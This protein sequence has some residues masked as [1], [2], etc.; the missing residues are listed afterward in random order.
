MPNSPTF[1]PHNSD[2]IGISHP[3]TGRRILTDEEVSSALATADAI[4]PP[5][6]ILSG[7]RLPTGYVRIE[8]HFEWNADQRALVSAHAAEALALHAEQIKEQN[9]VKKAPETS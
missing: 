6:V 4:N 3:Y 5:G 1:L 8:G 7:R 9:I 2:E